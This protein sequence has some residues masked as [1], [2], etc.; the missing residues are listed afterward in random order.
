MYNDVI[1]LVAEIKSVDEYGDI[2]TIETERE[3]F[4]QLLSISQ[5]EFYQAQAVGIKPELKFVIADYLDYNNEQIIRYK[6]FT[7]NE[8]TYS[9]IRTYRKGNQLEIVVKRGVDNGNA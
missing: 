6:G 9:V 7:N 4:A 5:S 3:V 2:K 8:E 1:K